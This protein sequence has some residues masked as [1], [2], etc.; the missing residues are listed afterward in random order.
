MD[1]YVAF[2]LDSTT[3]CC[4]NKEAVQSTTPVYS[5][6]SILLE[7]PIIYCPL[8]SSL[9]VLMVKAQSLW[10]KTSDP[11]PFSVRSE[12]E[13]WLKF[14][15]P[16]SSSWD[17]EYSVSDVREENLVEM[18]SM[19][20]ET[21]GALSIFGRGMVV[22]SPDSWSFKSSIASKPASRASQSVAPAFRSIISITNPEVVSLQFTVTVI[23]FYWSQL[24]I[25]SQKW[26]SR[27]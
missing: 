27:S 22:V 12:S 8:I 9:Y 7:A 17:T 18:V 1:A 4:F 20:T 3:L 15:Q 2:S 23:S 21:R 19:A 11:D 10:G 14:T 5:R 26:L 13:V 25:S 16:G 24:Q 6:V